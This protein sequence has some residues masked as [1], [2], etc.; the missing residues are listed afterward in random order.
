MV[1]PEARATDQ[2]TSAADPS[3]APVGQVPSEITGSSIE[4]YILSNPK[5][6]KLLVKL[7][8]KLANVTCVL[9]E[10]KFVSFP[11]NYVFPD[12]KFQC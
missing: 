3:T 11:R 4:K 9:Q 10:L 1:E 12:A 2:P 8:Y 5:A 6:Q 7:R